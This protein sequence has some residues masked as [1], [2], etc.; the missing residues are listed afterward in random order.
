MNP[1]GS[2]TGNA[3]GGFDN[4]DLLNKYRNDLHNIYMRLGPRD[5]YIEIRQEIIQISQEF[6]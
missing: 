4:E 2:V 3:V 5:L 6:F 1:V